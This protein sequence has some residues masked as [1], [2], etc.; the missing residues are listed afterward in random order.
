MKCSIR[1]FNS[2][3]TTCDTYLVGETIEEYK[4]LTKA[5]EL[6]RNNKEIRTVFKV[7]NLMLGSNLE[8]FKMLSQV[9]DVVF[10][11]NSIKNLEILLKE[12]IPCFQMA[13]VSDI[14]TLV[15]YCEMG[16]TDVYLAGAL[17]FDISNASKIAKGYGV[18]TR[19]LP[20]IVTHSCTGIIAPEDAEP[21]IDDFSGF[22]VNPNGLEL[23]EDYVDY[24]ELACVD[25]LQETVYEIYFLD[26]HYDG[27]LSDFLVNSKE[28]IRSS[29]LPK[30]FTEARLNCGKRC[31]GLHRCSKCFKYRVIAQLA[32]DSGK[33]I[34]LED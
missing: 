32:Q 28:A 21:Y 33:N 11:T 22:W 31:V 6:L 15:T 20:N 29:L 3:I 4:D 2:L 18:K 19:I 1:G 25:K 9:Y 23:Y 27:M 12:E 30:E 8:D 5:M 16:V 13:K 7:D 10:A 26:K 34:V 24:V 17:A 14:D